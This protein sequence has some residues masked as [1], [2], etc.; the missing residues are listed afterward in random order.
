MALAS[1]GAKFKVT[2]N[3][4]LWEK[5]MERFVFQSLVKSMRIKGFREGGQ[6]SLQLNMKGSIGPSVD[7]REWPHMREW[8]KNIMRRRD[9][10]LLHLLYGQNPLSVPLQD[11]SSS[12][13]G[14]RSERRIACYQL[15][16]KPRREVGKGFRLCSRTIKK[17][18]VTAI[19][20]LFYTITRK[21]KKRKMNFHYDPDHPEVSSVVEDQVEA[22]SSAVTGSTAGRAPP[23][24]PPPPPSS[25]PVES[26][27]KV[28]EPDAVPEM[29]TLALG[30]TLTL[31]FYVPHRTALL[32]CEV[33][34]SS[35]Y[36]VLFHRLDVIRLIEDKALLA[37]AFR[38]I[39]PDFYETATLEEVRAAEVA[40]LDVLHTLVKSGRWVVK[41]NLET[42]RAVSPM[43]VSKEREDGGSVPEGFG[44]TT[45]PQTED[46]GWGA[47]EN[48][49]ASDGVVR[50]VDEDLEV[51]ADPEITPTAVLGDG[52]E[53][54][55]LGTGGAVS[56]SVSVRQGGEE[57]SE[58]DMKR[59]IADA[60]LSQDAEP[61]IDEMGGQQDLP[62]QGAGGPGG[63][64]LNRDAPP[65]YV[66]ICP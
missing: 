63:P 29:N 52:A 44:S 4:R 33:R 43:N 61:V 12:M 35:L 46:A 22:G 23:S 5:E 49:I 65:V 11:R 6:L 17:S 14:G 2:R 62:C 28:K 38:S 64:Y 13:L 48:I 25:R 15:R 41:E 57:E 31:E 66:R 24:G 30:L 40:W 8:T 10:R 39:R 55:S 56:V 16:A 21:R 47:E 9:G 3:P 18:G 53:E 26:R 37:V 51:K 59:R 1:A 36:R 34:D 50:R 45:G 27:V 54:A 19:Y 60:L 20:T 58:F 32:G 42:S 7:L